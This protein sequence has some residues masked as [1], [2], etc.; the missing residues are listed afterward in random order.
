MTDIATTLEEGVRLHQAG[1]IQQ[2][3]A[4]YRRVLAAQPQNADALHLLGVALHQLGR[5]DDAL[6]LIMQA[7][8]V[9]PQVVD[10]YS[11]LGEI[12]LTVGRFEEAIRAFEAAVRLEPAD[13]VARASLERA[14]QFAPIDL[15]AK[16]PQLGLK[17][18]CP[19]LILHHMEHTGGVSLTRALSPRIAPD[20]FLQHT[21]NAQWSPWLFRESLKAPGAKRYRLFYDHFWVSS[22]L[23]WSLHEFIPYPTQYIGLVREPLSR[24]LSTYFWFRKWDGTDTLEP[25]LP[26]QA[27]VLRELDEFA[28]HMPRE[29]W[30]NYQTLSL[31]RI[32]T[33]VYRPR[34]ELSDDQLV[35][36]ALQAID[37][38][39]L[40]LTPTDLFNEGLFV[41]ASAMGWDSIPLWTKDPSMLSGAPPLTDVPDRI[42]KKLRPY[43]ELDQI[44][45]DEAKKRFF[46]KHARVIDVYRDEIAVFDRALKTVGKR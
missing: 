19:A 34:R 37:E 15:T 3:E 39:F 44:V 6:G 4:Q 35:E 25:P 45:Y 26:D 33:S 28:D 40:V 5:H 46:S 13:K 9:Q 1:Q 24:M 7:I 32:P 11:N 38:Y 36:A 43:N 16:R 42:L 12:C 30:W 8:K 22:I 2:A 29:Y 27:K 14:R 18:A 21:L 41:I 31:A 17:A 20:E 10:Y 23:H